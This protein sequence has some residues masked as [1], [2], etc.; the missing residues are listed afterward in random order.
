MTDHPFFFT[1][2]AQRGAEPF[3]II[4]GEGAFFDVQAAAGGAPERWLDMG[5]LSYQASLGHG[6]RR[7]ID[8]MKRQCDDLLLTV[9]S[10]TYPAKEALARKLLERAPPGFTKVF[11][12][13]GGAEAIENAI[14][15]A[16]LATKRSKLIAR[17]RSYHGATM[18]ALTLS[19]DHRRPPLEPGLAGVVHVLDQFESRV[20]GGARVI[21]G[22]ADADVIARTL[23][24]EGQGTVAA[25]FLEPVPGANGALVPPEGYWP[26]VRAACD[27]AGTLLVADCVLDGFGRLGTWYGFEGLGASPDLITLSKGLTGGYAPLGAVLVHERVAR[28]FD[29]E[30]LWA[31]LTFYGHPIGVAAALEALAVYEDE[32]LIERAAA[33]GAGFASRIA[34]MQDRHAAQLPKTRALGLLAGLEI[35]GDAARFARLSRALEERRIYAHP[36]ARARTLILAPPLVIA[37]RDLD[38]GLAAIEDAIA[39]S[40]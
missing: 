33:L 27:R 26:A 32:G 17:Y 22:G 12:T 20:P 21:E 36:N 16:R 4:G 14:K 23:E 13:L 9:P 3:A 1:W 25:I 31:G 28:A 2:S 15:I 35:A 34:A 39:A 40:A 29:D 8:A 6:C 5:S 7:V 24:L 30:V 10:G 18:G 38:A 19:G 37:E 11:F